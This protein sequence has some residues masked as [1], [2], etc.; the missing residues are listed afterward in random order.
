[1]FVKQNLKTVI[2]CSSEVDDRNVNDILRLINQS[3]EVG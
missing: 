2:N 3:P 1:M